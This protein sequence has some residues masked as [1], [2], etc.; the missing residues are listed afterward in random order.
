MG[1]I[2]VPTSGIL[3][4]LN[5]IVD[6]NVLSNSYSN[7]FGFTE[8]EV[9]QAI[10]YYEIESNIE[11]IRKWYNGYKFGDILIYNPWSILNY[12]EKQNFSVYSISTFYSNLIYIAIKNSCNFLFG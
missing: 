1:I 3:T 12:L 11:E 5:N 10:Q 9:K 4:G 7:I 6:Y 8:S 2:K